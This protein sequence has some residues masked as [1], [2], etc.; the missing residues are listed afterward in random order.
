MA[1]SQ[2]AETT[3][4]IIALR[5]KRLRDRRAASDE[6]IQ[7]STNRYNKLKKGA[8]H[9]HAGALPYPRGPT[10]YKH[11]V[12]HAG[13]TRNI[14]DR[15]PPRLDAF[16][17]EVDENESDAEADADAREA[18]PYSDVH[19]EVLLCPLKHPS[20]LA[21]HPS[22]SIPYLDPALPDMVTT[23]E[24]KL[25]QERANLWN[26]KNLQRQ[27]IGDESWIPLEKVETPDDWDLF[28]PKPRQAAETSLKRKRDAD[29]DE[30]TIGECAVVQHTDTNNEIA[31]AASKESGSV[32][33]TVVEE[34]HD[35]VTKVESNEQPNEDVVMQEGD[36]GESADTAIEPAPETNTTQSNGVTAQPEETA[37]PQNETTKDN[38]TT[39]DGQ[40]PAEDAASSTSST[41]PPPT[42]R[43]TRALAAEENNDSDDDSH[44]ESS[45]T[46]PSSLLLQPD[47]LFLIPPHLHP[48]DPHTRLLQTAA[49]LSLTPEEL[50]ETRSLLGLYIQK[51][52]EILRGY[53]S[54][55]QK[56]YLAKHRRDSVWRW[57]KAEGHV[58]EWSDGE[59]WVDTEEW[60]LPQEGEY[61]LRKGKDEDEV[62]AEEK[63]KER[64]RG[65]GGGGR[66]GNGEV[67]ERGALN[68][69]NGAGKKGKGKRRRNINN[70]VVGGHASTVTTAMGRSV[71][72]GADERASGSVQDEVGHVGGGSGRGG[73]LRWDDFGR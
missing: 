18:N 31:N 33:A 59:D 27:L 30:E 39:E 13:Y 20:E 48:T 71:A 29:E 67:D 22:L 2:H 64:E 49:S 45:S 54:L 4:V 9:V 68:R 58:D 11:P 65:L 34:A 51:Q 17:D 12:E 52:E 41:P 62:A 47:P 57:S 44:S 7:S 56:L 63:E 3:Q 14:L 72:N 8:G 61:A 50:L 5:R 37:E 25:R 36:H 21:T 32:A 40:D 53:E 70:H 10:G 46:A 38:H 66:N 23:T 6:P 42:R 28:E 43:I 24:E 60:E 15:N 55:L 1:P 26:A 73:G 19:L 69:A 16:G 35:A